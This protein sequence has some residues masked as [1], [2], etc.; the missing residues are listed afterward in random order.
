MSAAP[1]LNLEQF[2]PEQLRLLSERA[3]AA[4]AAA[5]SEAATSKARKSTTSKTTEARREEDDE[6]NVGKPIPRRKE[7]QRMEVK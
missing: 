3:A 1:A 5:E 4:A 6:S 2:T 7:W